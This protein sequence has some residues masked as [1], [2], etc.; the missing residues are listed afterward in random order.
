MAGAK[1]FETLSANSP[2]YSRFRLFLGNTKENHRSYPSSLFPNFLPL[3]ASWATGGQRI[4][5]ER[6]QR[7]GPGIRLFV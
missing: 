3:G 5:E 1:G 6:W 4:W 2:I 7:A